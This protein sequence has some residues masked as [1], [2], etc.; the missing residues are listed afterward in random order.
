MTPEQYEQLQAEFLRVRELPASDR[1]EAIAA[2]RPP[3]RDRLVALI[4]SDQACGSFLERSADGGDP[5]NQLNENTKSH[6]GAS[7]GT[8][9]A[10]EYIGRYRLLQKIGEGGH[11]SVYMAEQHEPIRRKVAL[12]VIKPGMDSKQV[13]ARF[14]AER[15]ALAMM[16]HPSIARVFDAGTTDAGTPFFVMELVKG[17]PIHRFCEDTAATVSER[18]QLFLQVCDAVHHAHRKGII[19]RDLKPTNVL[20]TMGEDEPIAKVID[21][22]IAKALDQTLTER[23]LFTEYGQMIGTL[24]YM[25]PEQAEMS[26]VEID[27]R[28]DVYSLGVLLYQLLTGETPISREQLLKHGV[29][30]I[31]RLLRETEPQTPSDRLTMRERQLMRVQRDTNRVGTSA[32]V[33]GELDWI[34]LKALAK[35]R[36]RRY[37]SVLDFAR[38]VRRYVNGE[39]VEAHPPSWR[40]KAL[41]LIQR[42][43]WPAAMSAVVAVG[44]LVGILGLVVGLQQARVAADNAKRQRAA[45]M[46]AQQVASRSQQA[47]AEAMY[48]EMLKSAWTAAGQRRN[49][50]AR[51]LLYGCPESIRGWEWR[52]AASQIHGKNAFA[53]QQAKELASI[54]E[55]Q[56]SPDEQSAA[57]VAQ[58]GSVQLW[59]VASGQFLWRV[60]L[61]N[62][63]NEVCW[64]P[65]A[66]VILVGTSR[67]QLHSLQASDGNRLAQKQLRIGGVYDI[68][69]AADGRQWVVSGG[70]GVAQRLAYD[71]RSHQ[72]EVEATWNVES[73]LAA[74]CFVAEDHAIIGAGLDGKL[75]TLGDAGAVNSTELANSS[76]NDVTQLKDGHILVRAARSIVAMPD[77]GNDKSVLLQTNSATLSMACIDAEWVVAGTGNGTLT[78]VSVDSGEPPRLIAD[79]G[80]AVRDMAWSAKRQQLLVALA[81]GRVLWTDVALSEPDGDRIGVGR[82]RFKDVSAGILLDRYNL[83]VTFD[84]SGAMSVDDLFGDPNKTQFTVQQQTHRSGVWSVATDQQQTI[85]VSVGEDQQVCCWE[86]PSF[87]RRFVTSVAWGVRDVAV[88]PDGSWIATAPDPDEEQYPQ[89]G[90]VVIRDAID[91]TVQRTLAGHQNWVLKMAVSDDGTKLATS[92][93]FANTRIWD[94]GTGEQRAKFEYPSRAAAP[95][96]DFTADGNTLLLGHRDGWVTSW[97]LL[98]GQCDAEWAAFGDAISGLEVTGD[99]RI[100]VSSRSSA[101]LKVLAAKPQRELASF[102]MG[103]GLILGF[104]LS[105]D[106][107]TFSLLGE[108][109]NLETRQMSVA[110]L[111]R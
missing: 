68:A 19:H 30:E 70:S 85:M 23:T 44:L 50:R 37:E 104:Q 41:K 71:L 76:L 105:A 86:L 63:A 34:S 101:R 46:Q 90:T 13:L 40:Y 43:R 25:S 58:D 38:D 27:T 8:F 33:R 100:V 31:P 14:H 24:E 103:H 53:N 95:L 20:V 60:Q 87:K 92:G 81:D 57:C 69:V 5:A 39:P 108:D 80:A 83:V 56:L 106:E 3:M 78:L 84:N 36:R 88:A 98:S 4:A 49:Q 107:R 97:D 48:S 7:D 22:G 11:G 94:P 42:Y 74:V 18:L 2:L 93:E 15:Q 28:S 79:L 45:A 17:V 82:L 1:E 111:A 64:S 75:Y 52:L 55:L 72:F 96:L 91:G 66:K 73:R 32:L 9:D 109:R 89:E 26:A 67:G 110:P 102:D 12:K 29:F 6:V 99:Q 61:P 35:D 51:E 54:Q 62:R 77:D 59:D 21:F 65:D 16:D 10:P 47:L